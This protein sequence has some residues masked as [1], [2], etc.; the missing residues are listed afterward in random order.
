[1]TRRP[2]L[3]L[4]TNLISLDSLLKVIDP[5]QLT[6]DLEGGLHY[7]HPAWIELRIVSLYA[8]NLF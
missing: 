6:T 8:L 3:F 7:D 5:S 4:Q 1:M 2:L